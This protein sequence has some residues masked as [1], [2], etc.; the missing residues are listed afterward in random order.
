MS[1]QIL[2]R[3]DGTQDV[4]HLDLKGGD[5]SCGSEQHTAGWKVLKGAR[6]LTGRSLDVL[7][8]CLMLWLK[9]LCEQTHATRWERST[10]HRRHGNNTA[11][12]NTH[13]DTAI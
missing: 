11:T 10:T 9:V 3:V 5:R 12:A 13:T 2:G 8:S 7:C 1:D 6:L 4:G